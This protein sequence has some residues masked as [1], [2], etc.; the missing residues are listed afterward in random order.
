MN[1]QKYI[2]MT[3]NILCSLMLVALLAS[4]VRESV[5]DRQFIVSVGDRVDLNFEMDYFQMVLPEGETDSK[6]V[7]G[8]VNLA[9]YLGRVILIQFTTFDCNMSFEK[10]THIEPKIWQRHKENPNFKLLGIARRDENTVENV[11]DLIERTEVTYPIARDPEQTFFTRFA[12]RN[13]G[14]TRDILIGKDGRIVMLTRYFGR[15]GMAEFN[16]L[17]AKIDELLSDD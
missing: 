6:I 15:D 3:K 1:S 17:V 2:I 12:E 13:G 11:K 9:D 16:A 4:C 8:T 7:Q 14:A 5:N 10:M